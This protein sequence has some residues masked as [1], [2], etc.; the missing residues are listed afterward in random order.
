MKVNLDSKRKGLHVSKARTS[1]KELPTRSC[2]DF[3]FRPYLEFLTV[4]HHVGDVTLVG[5]LEVVDGGV[6]PV[7]LFVGRLGFLLKLLL[8][9]VKDL[10]H[11]EK[12]KK[13]MRT[14][15]LYI[16]IHD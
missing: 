9:V 10:L 4:F 6:D 11:L 7:E 15:H 8:E 16:S 14:N 3:H 2:D 5:S 1:I 12:A 13:N